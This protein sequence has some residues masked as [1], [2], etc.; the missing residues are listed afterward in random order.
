MPDRHVY[1]DHSATTPVHHDVVKVMEKYFHDIYANP[2]SLHEIGRQSREIIESSREKIAELLDVKPNEIYFT[3]GGSEADNIAIKG[4][5]FK[6][7]QEKGHIITTQI[8]HKAVLETFRFLEDIGFETTYLPV[9]RFG[10]TDPKEFEKAIRDD[11]IVASIM[12]AN[13]EVGTVE[14]ISQLGSIAH[15]KGILFHTDAVQAVGKIPLDIEN[16]DMLSASAHKFY[17]PKGTGFLYM[18]NRTRPKVKPLIHGGAQE[19]KKRAG[20]ENI[21]GII[22]MTKALEIAM[23][24]MQEN[25]KR[26]NRLEKLLREGLKEK[27]EG[28]HFNGHPEIKLPGFLNVSFDKIEGESILLSMDLAGIYA[29]S[30]SAC[31]SKS[32]EPSHVL[33]AMDIDILLCHSSIRFTFGIDNTEEE[34]QYVLEQLP[35]IIDRLR[36][37]SVL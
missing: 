35:S 16:V 8:E 5:C 13:N 33:K 18:N 25:K 2:S 31:S 17:G 7:I 3:S 24:N 32:L 19:R 4:S 15:D 26:L 28:V 20:T 9:D 23:E 14:P 12:Y 22:G 10:M 34:V 1:L 11:T 21:A 37:I 36:E 27:I 30:G 29:S 6:R